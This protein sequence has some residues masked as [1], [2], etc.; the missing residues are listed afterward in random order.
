MNIAILAGEISGELI[1]AGLARELRVSAPEA[2]LWGLGADKMRDAGVELLEDCTG[3]SAISITQAV[4]RYP[5]LRFIVLPKV[6]RALKLRRPDVVVLIDFGAFNRRV[7]RESKR[8][9]LKVCWYF[10]PGAAWRRTGTKGANLAAITDVLVVP[11]EWSAQRLRSL[12]ANAISVGHPIVERTIVAAGRSDFAG[13]FG[14]DPTKPIIGLLPGSRM[15]EIEHLMPVLIGAARIIYS[16]VRDAQF[17]IGVAP[18]ISQEHVAKY[19]SVDRDLRDRVTDAWH[20]FGQEAESRI[21]RPVTRTAGVLTGQAQRQLVTVEG[22]VVAE[23]TLRDR[24]TANQR[25]DKLRSDA[26][27][28]LPPI[29]LAKGVTS[30][31]MAN[32]DVLLTCSGTATLEA[33]AFET[34]MVVLYRFS[35]LMELEAKLLGLRKKIKMIGLPNILA[36]K[37]IVPELIQH[38]ATPEAIAEN[39]L[40]LLNDVS[41]RHEAKQEL[42]KVREMMGEPGASARTARIVLDLA[43]V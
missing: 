38:D 10:P 33:A 13:R 16:S 31:I 4:Q 15:H 39:A 14:I 40:R 8:L 9:G 37:M 23:E 18:G 36:E 19:L 41:A 35:W 2:Q 21:I 25:S 43:G 7:A 32:S 30:D 11:F 6:L 1:G 17:I 22:V 12:G 26:E 3:W 24:D 34:P 20:E 29:V 5:H 27:R 42:H 28:A